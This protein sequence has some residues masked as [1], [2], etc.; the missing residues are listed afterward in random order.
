MKV[1]GEALK[2]RAELSTDNTSTHLGS[3]ETAVSKNIF[4]DLGPSIFQLSDRDNLYP[5]EPHVSSF[6]DIVHLVPLRL[7]LQVLSLGDD[8]KG[9]VAGYVHGAIGAGMGKNAALVS[10]KLGEFCIR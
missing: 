8:G 4:G 9:V 1:H 10:L 2:E 3:K 7:V 5:S 6:F